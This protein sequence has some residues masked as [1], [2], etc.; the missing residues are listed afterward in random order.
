[1]CPYNPVVIPAQAGIQ[2]G[3][4]AV[5]NGWQVLLDSALGCRVC[6][7]SRCAGMYCLNHWIPA[8]AGMTEEL[9]PRICRAWQEDCRG[10]DRLFS[11]FVVIPAKAGIH[12]HRDV[13]DRAAS[14]TSRR[15]GSNSPRPSFQTRLYRLHPCRRPLEGCPPGRG[16]RAASGT[17]G[18]RLQG[19]TPAWMQ[20]V[21]RRREQAAEVVPIPLLWR[22]AR[23]GGVVERHLEQAAREGAAGL[24]NTYRCQAGQTRPITNSPPF[25]PLPR[26]PATRH[27][28]PCH[29]PTAVSAQAS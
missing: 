9:W 15:G 12:A 19:C 18:R 22:G 27:N 28:P 14:A 21:E 1:M 5:I 7:H 20:V 6:C 4:D 25:T 11:V 10:S 29:C 2:E 13:G 8:F 23:Q 17:S 26:S 16:G 24:M 3:G